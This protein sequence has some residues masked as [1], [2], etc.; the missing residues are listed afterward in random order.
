[1]V[2]VIN[3]YAYVVYYHAIAAICVYYIIYLI[4]IMIHKIGLHNIMALQP[5][6]LC[7]DFTENT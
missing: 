3:L 6:I 5:L 2:V 4:I 7:V 1:M